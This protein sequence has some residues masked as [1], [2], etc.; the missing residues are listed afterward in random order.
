MISSLLMFSAGFVAG[1]AGT[2]IF[3]IRW[4]HKQGLFTVGDFTS[5]FK[6]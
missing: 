3:L 6:K 2:A 1:V 4:A 5:I